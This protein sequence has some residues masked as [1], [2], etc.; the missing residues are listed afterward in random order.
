MALRAE[1]EA[2]RGK[3]REQAMLI[4]RLQRRLGHGY[5]LAAPANGAST[6]GEVDRAR[7]RDIVGG[8]D[9]HR[10]RCAPR[11][12][13]W[14]PS[15]ARLRARD[16]G[17]TGQC[18]DQAGEIARLKAALA[19]F[20]Q[21]TA[22]T[23]LKDSKIALKARL[24]SAQAQA[25]QQAATIAKLRA[26]LAA[27]HERLAR[28]AAHFMDEMRRIGHR[29]HGP[30]RRGPGAAAGAWRGAQSGRARGPGTHGGTD[31]QDG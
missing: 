23:A 18:E 30:T 10:A 3:T 24:G 14:T 27:T 29:W 17:A 9:R 8:G 12:R 7:Q 28:Q 26:E 16:Q 1:I 20:E 6:E 25:D 22:R 11:G 19:A 13:R 5:A 2:L 21:Q 4:D 15:S 31:G